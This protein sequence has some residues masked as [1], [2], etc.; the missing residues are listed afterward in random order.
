MLF[1]T[2]TFGLF[3]FVIFFAAWALNGHHRLR[4]GL[5]VAAS[6][7]FYGFWD[8]RFT[9]LLAGSTALNWIAGEL[10][11]RS[12]GPSRRKIVATA[13]VLN[14]GVLGIFKYYD[15][16]L[17]SLAQ[18]LA[19]LGFSPSLPFLA[20]AVPVG[21]SFFTFHGISYVVDLA[22]GDLEKPA[23]PL[24]MLLYI[25]FFPQLVAG[26]IL[27]AAHFLP[28]IV[29]TPDADAIRARMA[30][31]LILGGLIK[32]VI[33]AN[34]L[35]VD[36]VDP[37]FQDPG[38]HGGA[39]LLLAAYGYALQIYCDFSAYTDIAI[40]LAALLGFRF[41]QNFDQ[42]YRAAS[43]R[44]FWRRWHMSLSAWLRDY[45]YIPLGGD[46]GDWRRY[47][48]LFLTMLL[49]GLWH[50]A[51]WH[52]VIWGALHGA[53]LMFERMTGMER[54]PRWI[55][56][57]ITFHFVCLCWVFFRAPDALAAVDFLLGIFRWE[58]PTMVTPSIVML[59]LVMACAQ[60]LPRDRVERLDRAMAGVPL[61][62]IGAIAG[63]AILAIDRVGPDGVAPFIYFA[64]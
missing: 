22:R 7:V 63:T 40:G 28:Q 20:I 15:F 16:F 32:K 51:A 48:N 57:L 11:W 60:F 18:A 5:L 33:V 29:K 9:L 37:V 43:L 53:W 54:L 2:L 64:F 21:L 17:L 27:R 47:R 23:R 13:V 35:A 44:D 34:S 46:S 26:P 49:G 19:T 59:M 38:G 45:F 31:L 56:V 24:D 8:W 50:G 14:L 30:L 3:F 25:S 62:L 39:D 55:G 12:E 52:F 10:V 4:V 6:Y 58:A 61:W 42:P 41:P 36:L 1:P